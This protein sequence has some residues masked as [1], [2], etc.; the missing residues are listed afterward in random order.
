MICVFSENLIR[1]GLST[2]RIGVVTDSF[3]KSDDGKS[4]RISKELKSVFLV[5]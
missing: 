2:L 5:V 1:Q 4:K 3:D